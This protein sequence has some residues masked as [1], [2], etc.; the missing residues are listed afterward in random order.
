LHQP[1]DPQGLREAGV[2]LASIDGPPAATKH[3]TTMPGADEIT[4]GRLAY[5]RIHGRDATAY[6]TGKKIAERFD[7]NYN[8][9]ALDEI[10]GRAYD[11]SRQ[12][13]EV[14]VV[15]TNN[16]RDYAPKAAERLRRKLAQVTVQPR[17]PKQADLF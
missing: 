8:D 3:F 11:L 7:Y 14:H 13:D 2:T 15:F 4:D 6:L 17:T 16:S 12:A 10:M 5:L 9:R 1:G